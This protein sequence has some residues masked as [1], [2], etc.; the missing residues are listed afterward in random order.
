MFKKQNAFTLIELMVTLAVLAI[1]IGVA[2]PSF[3]K[4]I[5]NSRSLTVGND[6]VTALNFARQEAV[7]RGKRVSICPST[8]GATCLTSGDWAKGWLVFEDGAAFDG[9]T[10]IVRMPLRQWSDLNTKAVITA[11]G[12]AAIAY[13]RFT[14]IGML[15]R[16]S[17]ADVSPRVFVVSATGCTG[18]S[19]ST[20]TVGLAGMNSSTKS[21][22]P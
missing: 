18:N 2:I 13:A 22:C 1:V 11:S 10:L 3:T 12:S 4:Q 14:G 20:I 19:K 21:A 9:D 16:L 8:D 15:A 7:K 6:L 17:N 5:T